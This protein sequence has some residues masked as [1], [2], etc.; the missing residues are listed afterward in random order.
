[1]KVFNPRILDASI[2]DVTSCLSDTQKADVLLHALH[3][4]P[5]EGYVGPPTAFSYRIHVL[6]SDPK[7]PDRHGECCSIVSP[8][9]DRPISR[10]CESPFVTRTNSLSRWVQNFCTTRSILIFTHVLSPNIPFQ[11]CCPYYVQIP[12]IKMLKLSY[13]LNIYAKR[14]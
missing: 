14:W 1:M 8:G 6:R 3:H 7:L 2:R 12:G 5:S 10:Y 11:T 4:L 13:N 9:L